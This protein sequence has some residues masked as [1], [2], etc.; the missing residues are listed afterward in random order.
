MQR[1]ENVTTTLDPLLEGGDD[2]SLVMATCS[3][4]DASLVAWEGMGREGR[5]HVLTTVR[6][7]PWTQRPAGLPDLSIPTVTGRPAVVDPVEVYVGLDNAPSR[8]A[9]AE[10]ALAEMD[11]TSASGPVTH[12]AGVADRDRIRELLRGGR[13]PV[14]DPG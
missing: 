5:R 4:S 1:I 11:W 13:G 9:R 3:G 2:R 7:Q 8:K 10:L 14:P 12:H 6:A